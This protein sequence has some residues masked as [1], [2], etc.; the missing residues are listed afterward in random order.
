MLGPNMRTGDLFQQAQTPSGSIQLGAGAWLLKSHA[1]EVAADLL[2]A[3]DL[4]TASAPWRHMVVP[5]GYQMSV[6][7]TNCGTYGWITD[8]TGYRYSVDDPLTGVPWPVMPESFLYLAQTA[9]EQAGY[10]G[11][12][13]DACLINRY[14]HGA[15]MGLHQD[16]DEQDMAQ[17]IV[18]ISLGLPAIFQFG[19]SKRSDKVE[20]ILLENGDAVVWGG[21]DRL[22]YHG[23]QPLKQGEHPLTGPY[24]YNLTFRKAR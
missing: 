18:S 10:A 20:R 1:R 4:M 23:I 7:M 9:A 22:R 11:F 8:R 15:K 12:T 21:P 2:A 5:G 24:R 13:P 6:A 17:P 3:I 19:G 16:K 14:A